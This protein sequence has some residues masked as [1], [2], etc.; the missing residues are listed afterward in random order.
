MNKKKIA[1]IISEECNLPVLDSE[2]A[3]GIVLDSIK[4]GV[5]ENGLVTFQNFGS[6]KSVKYAARKGRN[7]KTG[8]EI[9]IPFKKKVRFKALNE[10]S[11][12]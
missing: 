11:W 10:E 3:V 2:K 12:K 9:D 1:R 6:F 7:P 5:A 4:K 8:E